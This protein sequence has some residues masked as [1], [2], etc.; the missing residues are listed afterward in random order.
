MEHQ[1]VLI[2]RAIK[3]HLNFVSISIE[4]ATEWCIF[5][6]AGN[7]SRA[8]RSMEWHCKVSRE[9]DIGAL[10]GKHRVCH[11]STPLTN[12]A[13]GRKYL[14][15]TLADRRLRGIHFDL[16]LVLHT[17]V[18]EF[19]HDLTAVTLFLG[20]FGRLGIHQFSCLIEHLC[21]KGYYGT[22]VPYVV[23]PLFI[24]R[25][26]PLY[27]DS[28][29]VTVLPVSPAIDRCHQS[30][31]RHTWLGIGRRGVLVSTPQLS[32]SGTQD[33]I[34]HQGDTQ[35]LVYLLGS[36]GRY[37]RRVAETIDGLLGIIYDVCL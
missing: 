7:P 18:A 14:T 25:P 12:I 29:F 11:I 9:Y 17:R 22:V 27:L 19:Y 35:L 26:V 1:G 31:C 8:I 4:V 28:L 2:I 10:A 16:E 33:A 24:L 36:Q 32:R 6:I 34:A 3:L 20:N 37:E 21:F 15:L 30:E 23:A 13:D 5:M